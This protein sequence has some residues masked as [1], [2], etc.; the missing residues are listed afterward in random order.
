MAKS[1]ITDAEFDEIAIRRSGLCRGVKLKIMADGRLCVTMP[2]GTPLFLAKAVVAQSRKAIRSAL[3]KVNSSQNSYK[4][5]DLIGKSHRLVIVDGSNFSSR[6]CSQ[7]LKI[8]APQ[9][10]NEQEL[11]NF[12]KASVQKSMRW[13]AK[14][15]LPPRIEKLAIENGFSYKTLR[16]SSAT[17]RWGS[18][19]TNK[20]I[21]LNIWLMQLP[22]EVI[23][24]VIVHELCHTRHMNHSKDFWAL[25]E[26]IVPSHRLYR[27]ILKQHQPRA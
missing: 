1:S 22:T 10:A 3:T 2:P 17:S 9:Q 11:Q 4:N 20:T 26:T 27:T 6:I 15:F 12:I 14:T 18:C 8:I 13:Q 7:E 19:S 25:V 16:F 5:G 24:Y 21:S 23:D